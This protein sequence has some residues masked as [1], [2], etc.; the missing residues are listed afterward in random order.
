MWPKPP[1]A[2]DTHVQINLF[3]RF[4]FKAGGSANKLA[5]PTKF[6]R[7][8]DRL[9]RSTQSNGI[10]HKS[11]SVSQIHLDS[12]QARDTDKMREHCSTVGHRPRESCST[13]M[14]ESNQQ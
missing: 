13:W 2:R 7:F 11:R 9:E 8:K 3:F 1:K 14:S 6:Q 12:E 10:D 5:M 4:L